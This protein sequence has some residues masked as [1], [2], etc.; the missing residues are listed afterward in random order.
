LKTCTSLN[1]VYVAKPDSKV[2]VEL[3]TRHEQLG[4]VLNPEI[5]QFYKGIDESLPVLILQ[6]VDTQLKREYR[7]AL[8]GQIVAGTALLLMAGGFIFLVMNGH[9]KPAYILLGAGVLNVI[10]GFLRAR[11]G[12]AGS[13]R[14]KEKNE[15]NEQR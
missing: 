15:P 2:L 1:E 12:D 13:K 5:L 11:L 10:G 14:E 7:Y 6:T 9:D 8:G 4:I 3:L